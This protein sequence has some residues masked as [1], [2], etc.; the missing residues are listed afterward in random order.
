MMCGAEKTDFYHIFDECQVSSFIKLLLKEAFFISTAKELIFSPRA[1]NLYLGK[2]DTKEEDVLSYQ[3]LG[4]YK[5]CLHMYQYKGLRNGDFCDP[6]IPLEI[7]NKAI[8]MVKAVAPKSLN[9]LPFK[10]LPKILQSTNEKTPSIYSPF[11]R[12]S[13]LALVNLNQNKA[14]LPPDPFLPPGAPPIVRD[15][16]LSSL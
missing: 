10:K 4:A 11:L 14:H 2:Y 12:D 6:R 1:Q 8:T 3:F 13:R 5:F 7:A 16:P 9:I 15:V